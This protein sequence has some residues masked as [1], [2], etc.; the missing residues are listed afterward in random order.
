M[1]RRPPRSTRTD[2]LC[3]YTTLFRS[4]HAADQRVD[5]E[6]GHCHTFV[7]PKGMPPGVRPA[8]LPGFAAPA[9]PNDALSHLVAIAMTPGGLPFRLFTVIRWVT[10]EVWYRAD[11]VIRLLD[12]FKIDHAQPSWP[13]N[14]W[15]SAM[16]VLFKPQIAELLRG[17]DARVAAWQDQN[18]G[19]D[20]FE[21]RDLEVT[22]YLDISV[23]AQVRAVAN[24]LLARQQALSG[25]VAGLSGA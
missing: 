12:V 24:A 3:P 10:G 23:E 11:D 9:D 5:G 4:A 7:R 22:S 19:A 16:V 17:R 25:S 1:R 14:R 21:D 18:P 15:I 20:V 13:V 2:T 6:H 8:P